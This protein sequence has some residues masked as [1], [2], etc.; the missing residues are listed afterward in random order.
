VSS[1]T[2]ST[3]PSTA[4]RS[5]SEKRRKFKMLMQQGRGHS[6]DELQQQEQ[7][8]RALFLKQLDR[9]SSQ[10]STI[11]VELAESA[12]EEM[13]PQDW[14]VQFLCLLQLADAAE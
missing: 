12:V 1:S 2:V 9:L 4:S 14:Q 3:V 10:L 13:V 5:S 8:A 7:A 11:Y 6:H